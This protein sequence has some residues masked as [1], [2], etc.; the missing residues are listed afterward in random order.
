M[1]VV[2]REDVTL[3]DHP[4]LG[5]SLWSKECVIGLLRKFVEQTMRYNME[6]FT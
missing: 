1:D 3:K 2:V 6:G 5:Q 4:N